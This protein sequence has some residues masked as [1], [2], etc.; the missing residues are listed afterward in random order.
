MTHGVHLVFLWQPVAF[1]LVN[2]A[3]IV[4]SN[5]YNPDAVKH[6]PVQFM[7]ITLGG[8]KFYV[9]K[10]RKLRELL[11]AR[12]HIVYEGQLVT[13]VGVCRRLSS[14]VVVCRRL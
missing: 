4:T 13:V 14:V 12:L 5:F 7:S 9:Y 2:K 10:L 3:K 1:I 8:V 11:L 6:V